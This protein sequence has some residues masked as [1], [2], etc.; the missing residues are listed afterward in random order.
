MLNHFFG[1]FDFSGSEDCRGKIKDGLLREATQ[2][3]G[4]FQMES[5]HQDRAF[6]VSNAFT[7]SKKNSKV[8][9]ALCGDL[10]DR[11]SQKAVTE[12]ALGVADLSGELIKS[13]LKKA[14]GTFAFA[15]LGD[16]LWLATDFLGGRPLFHT[17]YEGILIFSTSFEL[18]RCLIPKPCTLDFQAASE[19]FCFGYP[20]ADRT[21]A[22][23]IKVL[24][25]GEYIRCSRGE[26]EVAYYERFPAELETFKTVE[27]SLEASA[28]AIKAAINDRIQPGDTQAALLSGGL[29]SRVIVSELVDAGHQ[30]TA[31]NYS[32]AGTLDRIFAEK[33]SELSG[34]NLRVNEFKKQYHCLSQGETTSFSLNSAQ[35]GLPPKKIFSG[36]GGGEIF[37][38]IEIKP[39]IFQCT[40]LN[41]FVSLMIHQQP[42]KY[43]AGN[44]FRTQVIDACRDGLRV[45]L[46]HIGLER[47]VKAVYILYIINDL[48]RHLHEYFSGMLGET[49]ELL[50]PYYDRR[51][52]NAALRIPVIS[53]EMIGHGY[54]YRLLGRLSPII[55]IVPWQSYP[56]SIACPIPDDENRGISQWGYERE[57]NKRDAGRWAFFTLKSINL[58]TRR[59]GVHGIILIILCCG[60]FLG[61]YKNSYIFKQLLRI[62]RYFSSFRW[63]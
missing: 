41:D 31:A 13:M 16:E 22:K 23:E 62:N 25:G 20:L 2:I 18:I 10:V 56:G 44:E 32:L 3:V 14:N 35:R 53:K 8:S 12:L 4:C 60:A 1:Y 58:S 40:G 52:I 38:F 51:V 50:L 7:S 47:E 37:G 6:L 9:V 29:D 19:D 36:D 59:N 54:Y 11:E 49:R 46:E 21:L 39:Q 5:W 33:F 34:I 43:I 61:L 57:N 27:S 55:K 17:V 42:S 26:F 63:K 48:R 30:V 15:A 24:Q 45:Q 28:L